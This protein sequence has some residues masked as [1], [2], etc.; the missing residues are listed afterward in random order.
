MSIIDYKTIN[1][2]LKHDRQKKYQEKLDTLKLL[3]KIARDAQSKSKS[4][5][6]KIL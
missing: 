6:S 1:A 4:N 5:S 2:Q 3:T